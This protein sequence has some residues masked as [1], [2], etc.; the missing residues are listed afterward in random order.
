MRVW[1]KT[2]VYVVE[3]EVNS[4][5][6]VRA[7]KAH[8]SATRIC[9]PCSGF[10]I[11]GSFGK[12]E[13]VAVWHVGLILKRLRITKQRAVVIRIPEALEHRIIAAVVCRIFAEHR[14][15]NRLGSAKPVEAAVTATA[16]SRAASVVS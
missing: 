2:V 1:L 4:G 5:L 15:G 7:E 3:V 6:A 11:I 16:G 9:I 14:P 13:Y 10:A 8:L 12:V